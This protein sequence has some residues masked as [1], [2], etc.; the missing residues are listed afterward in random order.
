MR[1]TFDSPL[2]FYQLTINHAKAQ[3][4]K[5]FGARFYRCAV[6]PL[7]EIKFILKSEKSVY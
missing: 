4:R 1:S 3:R 6:A 7:R 2:F 5:E